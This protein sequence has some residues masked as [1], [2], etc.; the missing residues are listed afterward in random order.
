MLTWRWEYDNASRRAFYWITLDAKPEQRFDTSRAEQLVQRLCDEQ[1]IVW[2][3]VPH[4]GGEDQLREVQKW[5]ESRRSDPSAAATGNSGLEDLD[6]D[7]RFLV[8]TSL[9][10]LVERL[11]LG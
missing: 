3:P 11:G 5:I 2:R 9:P 10:D 8:Q 6:M 7:Q 4:P 1:S